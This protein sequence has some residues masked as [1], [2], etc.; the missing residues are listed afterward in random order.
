MVDWRKL[1]KNVSS[2]TKSNTRETYKRRSRRFGDRIE[3]KGKTKDYKFTWLTILDVSGSVDDKEI[4]S[5]LEEVILLCKKMNVESD[6]IQVDTEAYTST[7]IT[8]TLRN[9][10][11]SASGG[12]F[13][14]AAIAQAKTEKLEYD[15]VLVLTDGG[16]ANH[17]IDKFK[18]LHCNVIFIVTDRTVDLSMFSAKNVKSAYL[19][20]SVA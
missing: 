15:A 7:K 4:V 16:L 3:V 13:L 6:M 18:E 5:C 20:K 19:S 12:T 17:D 11:R 10:N 8:T 9:V 1:F 2:N 14:S